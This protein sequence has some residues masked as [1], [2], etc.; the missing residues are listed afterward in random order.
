VSAFADAPVLPQR[1]LWLFRLAF[2]LV[3]A[4]CRFLAPW[5]VEGAGHI[6]KDGAFILVANHINWKD[7]PWIE[8]MMNRA[9]RFMAKRELFSVPVV[10]FVLRA[11]GAFPVRRGEADRR[12]MQIAMRVLQAGHPLGFFPEGHRSESGALIRAR[13]GIAQIALQ[14][15][16]LVVP[17]AVWGTRDAKLGRFWRADIRFRLGEP[18]RARDLGLDANDPQA[19]ADAIM[20]RVAELLPEKMRGVYR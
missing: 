19:V 7:P 13:P 10:G 20:R 3:R 6:P 11:I 8:F 14:S 4:V 15:D 18:F 2:P 5:R 1:R 12:A 17:L 16:A 9:I